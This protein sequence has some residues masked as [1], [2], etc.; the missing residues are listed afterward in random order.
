MTSASRF[1][2]DGMESELRNP[3]R[4]ACASEGDAP[5]PARSRVFRER[6]AR[7]DHCPLMLATS[8]TLG[9]AVCK[10]HPG[11]V[12]PHP[13]VAC[14][15]LTRGDRFAILATDGLWDVVSDQEAVS[16]VNKVLGDGTPSVALCEE[17]ARA[18]GNMAVHDV[19]EQAIVE[20][21]GVLAPTALQATPRVISI[22]AK[23]ACSCTSTSLLSSSRLTS[24]LMPPVVAIEARFSGSRARCHMAEAACSRAAMLPL[25]ASLTSGMIPPASEMSTNL[26]EMHTV[27]GGQ[28]ALGTGDTRGAAAKIGQYR[29]R[30]SMLHAA[31]E[32][33]SL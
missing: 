17:A 3:T 32:C 10:R 7:R 6:R 16:C 22:S 28:S 14:R 19:H 12:S 4:K 8:R 18:L 31:P 9:D 21:Q 24:G 29:V 13:D 26:R 25:S 23:A 1:A 30:R 5:M 2:S 33:Q 20:P 15:A 11:L 27:A